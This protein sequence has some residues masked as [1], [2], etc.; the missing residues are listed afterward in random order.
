MRKSH[1]EALLA[2]KSLKQKKSKNL[3]EELLAEPQ[4]TSC[5]STEDC[6]EEVRSQNSFYRA[7]EEM[8]LSW[9]VLLKRE[10]QIITSAKST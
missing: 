2:Q 1:M 4:E 3:T 6:L 7:I 9:D 8:C 5:G 10:S